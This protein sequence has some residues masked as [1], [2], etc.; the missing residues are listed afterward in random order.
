MY[1]YFVQNLYVCKIYMA[2][3]L[4]EF[5]ANSTSMQNLRGT[6]LLLILCKIDIYAESTWHCT[7][8][9]SMQ[10]RHLRGIYIA[11]HRYGF[12]AKSTPL[13]NPYGNTECRFYIDFTSRQN[14]YG[15]Y[16]KLSIWIPCNTT[17]MQIPCRTGLPEL[18]L[19]V[20]YTRHQLCQP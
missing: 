18:S 2:L 16:T 6:A 14:S 10:N 19:S 11:P 3:H 4:R 20:L 9:D 12:Y 5:C 15:F 8:M 17:H 13:Q 1:V 7:D